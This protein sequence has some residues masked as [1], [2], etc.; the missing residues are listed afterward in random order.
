[1]LRRTLIA[2]AALSAVAA[3]AIAAP[4]KLDYMIYAA[5][6]QALSATITYD[7]ASDRYSLDVDGKT[8]GTIG[9][10]FPWVT[11]LVSNG[12]ISGGEVHPLRHL[13]ESRF[14]EQ[15]RSTLLEYD[16][17]GGFVARKVT[18]PPSEDDAEEVAPELT[19][20][21]VDLLSAVVGALLRTDQ[22]GSC[23]GR[24]SVYDGRRRFE[25]EFKS[26]GTTQM[27]A[28]SYNS[29]AGP[30]QRCDIR[31]EPG[32]GFWRKNQKKW[33]TQ[34]DG[35]LPPVTVWS[36]P[37]GPDKRQVPV[38]IESVSPFGAVVVQL[39]KLQAG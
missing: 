35:S 32:P 33:F 26:G 5:G 9:T 31:V 19:Q 18:P 11:H 24:N 23:A 39:T 29:Y 7:S 30:A 4:V 15:P 34:K 13:V 38:K 27:E 3:P 28:S 8:A 2:A 6:L 14:K 25:V 21:T 12:K 1:M 10:V 37:G 16:G 36:A 17:K 22:T 20:N